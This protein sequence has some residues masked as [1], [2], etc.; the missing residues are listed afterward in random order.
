MHKVDIVYGN[1]QTGQLHFAGDLEVIGGSNRESLLGDLK[2]AVFAALAE[3]IDFPA[4]EL[5]IVP[6]DRVVLAVDPTVPRLE[7]VIAQVIAYF[8]S[9]GVEAEQFSVV[10]AGHAD[11][12]A[13]KLSAALPGTWRLKSMMLTIKR[14]W[15][16]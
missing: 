13:N 8:Q 11:V 15:L 16:M 6:G 12:D 10:L 14:R 3:P 9:R 7:E 1:S 4:V 5:A 2:N